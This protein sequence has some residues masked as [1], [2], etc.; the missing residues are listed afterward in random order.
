MRPAT[1]GTRVAGAEASFRITRARN[2]TT[3][4]THLHAP[5]TRLHRALGRADPVV[6]PANARVVV[7]AK[8]WL[9]DEAVCALDA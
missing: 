2:R 8:A 7:L 3:P 9:G 1:L 4:V 6:V 5:A